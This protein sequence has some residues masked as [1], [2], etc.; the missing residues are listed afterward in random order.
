MLMHRYQGFIADDQIPTNNTIDVIYGGLTIEIIPR[1][2]VSKPKINQSHE[3][4]YTAHIEGPITE[5]KV[6]MI[7]GIISSGKN[8]GPKARKKNAIQ[9]VIAQ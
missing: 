7:I 4:F 9:E 8:S 1:H 5:E 3:N 2:K 6:N